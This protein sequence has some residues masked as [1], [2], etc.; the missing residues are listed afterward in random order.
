MVQK[1][2]ILETLKSKLTRLSKLNLTVYVV[3]FKVDFWILCW[4]RLVWQFK[5]SIPSGCTRKLRLK[6][7]RVR[8]AIRILNSIPNSILFCDIHLRTHLILDLIRALLWA[9]EITFFLTYEQMIRP[10]VSEKVLAKNWF[11]RHSCGLSIIY[12]NLWHCILWGLGRIGFKG[13]FNLFW[14]L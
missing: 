10:I 6:S 14:F 9:S 8:I 11:L 3:K 7:F 13:T 12:W 5:K 2:W 4:S 1:S